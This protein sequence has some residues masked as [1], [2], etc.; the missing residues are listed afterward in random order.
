[1]PRRRPRSD[2]YVAA[3]R[4]MGGATGNT[5]RP[6]RR[7]GWPGRRRRSM[8]SNLRRA[9]IAVPSAPTLAATRPAIRRFPAPRA[10]SSRSP[11]RPCSLAQSWREGGAASR[12]G[13]PRADPSWRSD[14]EDEQ[15]RSRVLSTTILLSLSLFSAPIPSAMP[16]DCRS[17]ARCRVSV[18]RRDL[19]ELAGVCR[20]RTVDQ[21]F[22]VP[23][24]TGRIRRPLSRSA[25]KSPACRDSD[26][27]STVSATTRQPGNCSLAVAW[28]T[29]CADPIEH[30][31]G[32]LG[33]Q[34]RSL[35]CTRSPAAPCA[36]SR[37]SRRPPS[38]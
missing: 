4:F 37:P 13:R 17:A 1:M 26:T 30:D 36:P 5:G 38:T 32:V 14:D 29:F 10:D 34:C 11:C 6:I 3:V 2:H 16:P 21:Q 28:Q 33:G 12:S 24:Q 35:R 20:M 22:V 23:R 31:A 18:G 25:A 7:T 8:P 9:S 27:C 15:T 19:H